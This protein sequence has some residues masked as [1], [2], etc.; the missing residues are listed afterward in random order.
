MEGE[1]SLSLFLAAEPGRP[2][3]DGVD[4][5]E[6]EESIGLLSLC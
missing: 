3:A 1:G 6:G 2:P 4:A 5:G